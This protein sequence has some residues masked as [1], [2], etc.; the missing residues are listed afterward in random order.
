MITHF[1]AKM[2]AVTAVS[3][4][5]LF[6]S[7]KAQDAAAG[8]AL[9]KTKC[10]TCHGQAGEGIAIFPPIA[11][12]EW[13]NGPVENLI[14]IQLHGL[15]GP[16]EVKGKLYNSVMPSNAAMTDKEIAD[17]LTYIR[18][19]MGNSAP[20][21]TVDM[22]ASHRDAAKANPAPIKAEDLLDPNVAPEVKE[23]PLS[24]PTELEGYK[25]AEH[26]SSGSTIF[27]VVG[28]IGFCTLPALV[29]LAKN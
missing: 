20:A 23:K 11:G 18:S 17:V 2:T 28:I 15:M 1:L 16:I 8:E 4:T 26:N 12:S 5:A 27:W 19:S 6:S 10:A 3:L 25:P 21:V 13:V 29:G 22:V 14:R 9:F 24:G 7:A